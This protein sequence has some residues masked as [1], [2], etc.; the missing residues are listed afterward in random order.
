M[1]W[2][3]PNTRW[4][5]TDILHLH[6]EGFHRKAL[7]RNLPRNVLYTVVLISQFKYGITSKHIWCV[8]I[9]AIS[10]SFMRM[11]LTTLR[12]WYFFSFKIS[13]KRVLHN[14]VFISHGAFLLQAAAPTQMEE[15]ECIIP[16]QWVPQPRA[17][18]GS[19][20]ARWM[21]SE[22]PPPRCDSRFGALT[23]WSDS[24]KHFDAQ[25]SAHFICVTLCSRRKNVKH[26]STI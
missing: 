17:A 7:G 4:I 21:I 25:Y 22:R 5:G 14:C 24:W 11:R 10:L 3:Y 12:H 6:F 15:T 18:A 8:L 9:C 20:D 13:Q 1:C 19:C 23:P 26:K 16:V 2:M